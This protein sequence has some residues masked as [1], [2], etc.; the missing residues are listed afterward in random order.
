VALLVNLTPGGWIG[1]LIVWPFLFA[2][3][4]SAWFGGTGPGLT[5]PGLS[6]AARTV[7]AASVDLPLSPLAIGLWLG[8]CSGVEVPRIQGARSRRRRTTDCARL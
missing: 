3:L 8:S 7:L 1:P 6:L 2:V 4:V 5:A